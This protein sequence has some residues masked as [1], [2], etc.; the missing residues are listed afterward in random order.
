M[1]A[2]RSRSNADAGPVDALLANPLAF[3]AQNI[4]VPGIDGTGKDH[5]DPNAPMEMALVTKPADK[6]AAARLGQPLGLYFLIPASYVA[7]MVSSGAVQ[8]GRKFNTYFCSTSAARPSARCLAARP[9]SCSPR[10]WMAAPSR[11]A[12]AGPNGS[13][14]VYHANS[15]GDAAKQAN[16]IA[17]KLGTNIA[18]RSRLPTTVPTW[19]SR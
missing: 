2:T 8:V 1:S 12:S 18:A 16:Q 6:H 4:V 13:R 11:S 14:L 15:G 9:T 17:A 5:M 3:M 10:R 19:G 7:T